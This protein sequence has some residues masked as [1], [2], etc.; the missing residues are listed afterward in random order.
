MIGKARNRIRIITALFVLVGVVLIGRLYFL[1]VMNGDTFSE[2]ADRQYASPQSGSFDRGSIFFKNKDGVKISAATL[3]SGFILSINPKIIKNPDNLYNELSSAVLLNYDDFVKKAK[4]DN[5]PYEEVL[6]RLSEEEAKNVQVMNIP[7]VGVYR[8]KW[9]YYPGETLASHVLGFVGFKED[10]LVGRYGLERYYED[11]LRRSDKNVYANFFTEIFSGVKTVINKNS[12]RGR[13]DIVL[14]IEPSVQTFLE[15]ELEAIS[16]KWNSKSSGGVVI[17]PV[18]GEIFALAVYP[19]FNPNIFQEES[20]ISIFSN[21]I[22]E[23]VFEMGSIMKSITMAIGLDTGVVG[24]ESTYNDRG[25]IQFPGARISNYDGKARG[26][27]S[28]QRVLSESLNTGAAYVASE[29]GNGL[30]AEYLLSFGIDEETGI[31][32]PSETVGIVNNLSSPRDIEYATA[33]FGQGIAMTPIATVRALSVLANGGTL[34]TPHIV[35]EIKN[36]VGYNKNIFYDEGERVIK[37][38]TSEEITRMLVEVVDEAL[39]GGTVK[40]D[41]YTIAAKTGTAQIANKEEGGYYD[42]RFFHSFFGYF[43]AFEPRFLIFL[44]TLE[45]KEVRFASNTLTMPFIDT[46]KFL[47]N[48]YEIP[49]DR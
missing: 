46:T 4:K 33:S 22:V 40:L 20:N 37:R 45:P 26:I 21:P 43:P 18:S 19:S 49:P 3:Q 48:Y 25:F 32:L 5:D 28:M 23:S 24:A 17:D 1:Q 14:T 36:N 29:I 38:E 31:D 27:S 11:T 30:F 16:S 8:E 41:R 34:I 9:R 44:Y 7:G 2:R 12:S 35:D 39:L 6:N 42:D 10:S 15:L 13:G 47:I